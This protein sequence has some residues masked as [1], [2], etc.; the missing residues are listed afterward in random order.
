M[1]VTDK[2]VQMLINNLLAEGKEYAYIT[3]YLSTML[4]QTIEG[5]SPKHKARCKDNLDWHIV[6]HSPKTV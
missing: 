2:Q 5:A 3:G 1:N 6:A 4:V